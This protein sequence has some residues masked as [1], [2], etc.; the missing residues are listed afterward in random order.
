MNIAIEPVRAGHLAE[1]SALAGV[2]DTGVGAQTPSQLISDAEQA[3]RP[4]APTYAGAAV[5]VDTAPEIDGSSQS[6]V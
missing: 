5:S 4:P 6:R 3:D 1:I 2:I